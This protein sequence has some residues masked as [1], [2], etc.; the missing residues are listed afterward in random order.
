MIWTALLFGLMSSFHCAIMCG[1]ILLAT[2]TGTNQSFLLNSRIIYHLG[3]ISTYAILGGLMGLIG[4]GLYLS[5]LQQGISIISG[6]LILLFI[7]IPRLP[8]FLFKGVGMNKLSSCYKS[9]FASF[10]QKRGLFAQFLTGS[11][12]GILPCGMVYIAMAAAASFRTPIDSMAY[13]VLFGFGTLPMLL[14]I[15]LS[16]TLITFNFRNRINK[17]IPYTSALLGV[18]FILRGMSL[19]IP[20]LSPVVGA[21]KSCCTKSCHVVKK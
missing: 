7:F 4:K 1:P 11:I 16:G 9:L 19:D 6:V 3:R 14:F 5:G 17:L 21:E 10:L 8:S 2:T 20:Y 12:N 15:S 13:M 18:I